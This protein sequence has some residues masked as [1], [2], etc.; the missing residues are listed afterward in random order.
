MLTK[1]DTTG[2]HN[3]IDKLHRV[4]QENEDSATAVD[5]REVIQLMTEYEN[6]EH[7]W[8]KYAKYHCEKYTRNLIDDGK[9]KFNLILMAW[10]PGQ[11]TN[12]HD[13]SSSS[14]VMRTLKGS[15][16]EI[17]YHVPVFGGND[18]HDADAKTEL[19]LGQEFQWTPGDVSYIDDGI[20]LHEMKNVTDVRAATLHVY[21]PP[22]NYCHRYCRLDGRKMK[23]VVTF[24]SMYGMLTPFEELR[25]EEDVNVDDLPVDDEEQ[26]LANI[27][28]ALVSSFEEF[29]SENDA[30]GHSSDHQPNVDDA[31]ERSESSG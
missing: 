31:G 18:D 15:I 17:R 20:G 3:L 10:S 21:W 25:S 16:T 11:G 24:H 12:I 14:C 19:G 8:K 9:G 22:Y 1:K 7:D 29:C 6:N 23:N 26:V 28:E 13:H 2:L 5:P 4:F 30:V 27:Q